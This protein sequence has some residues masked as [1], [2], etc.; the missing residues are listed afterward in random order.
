MSIF[1]CIKFLH[2]LS[3]FMFVCEL[4]LYNETGWFQMAANS[5]AI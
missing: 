2:F 3:H 1:I 4:L 5:I